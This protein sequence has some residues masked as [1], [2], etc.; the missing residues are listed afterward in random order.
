MRFRIHL[1]RTSLTLIGTKNVSNESCSDMWSTFSVGHTVSDAT[2]QKGVIAL[3]L[4]SYAY[5][6]LLPNLRF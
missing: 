3:Q 6:S 2:K 1:E 5:A 4:L